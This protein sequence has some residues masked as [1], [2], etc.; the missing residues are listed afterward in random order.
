MPAS[1][2]SADTGGSTKVAGSSIEMVAIGPIPGSTPISVPRSTPMKQYMMLL[3]CSA[4][5]KPSARL[6]S[7]SIFL[8]LASA[9][10]DARLERLDIGAQRDGQLES[11]DE[12]ERAEDAED[13]T[14]D[15]GAPQLE[16]RAADGGEDDEQDAGEEHAEG[17]H[18]EA[19]EH[20]R[21]EHPEVGLPV[22]L[23]ECAVFPSRLANAVEGDQQPEEEE[24]QP[25]PEREERRPHPCRSAHRVSLHEGQEGNPLRDQRERGAEGCED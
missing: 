18:H 21:A 24:Q 12:D 23:R 7:S 11:C 20:D 14:E 3:M 15:D 1:M 16:L 17:L 4:T 6:L 22:E 25:E 19:E 8:L 2:M 10:P 5:P 9:E 13:E